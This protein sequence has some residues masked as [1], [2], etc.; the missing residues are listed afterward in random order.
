MDKSSESAGDAKK[1]LRKELLALRN[2]LPDRQH[3]SELLQLF[4][5]LLQR[6]I[7]RIYKVLKSIETIFHKIDKIYRK[8]GVK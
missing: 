2:A 7:Q 8:T 5:K 4:K 6:Q 1:A 3:R